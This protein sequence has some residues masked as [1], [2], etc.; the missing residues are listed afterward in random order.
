MSKILHALGCTARA[1][2]R[3]IAACWR[4]LWQTLRKPKWRHG[5]YGFALLAAAVAVGILLNIAVDSLEDTYGWRKDFSFNGYATTGA[6]TQK[7]LDT[8][9]QDVNL[10]LLYQSGEMDSQLYEV[11]E[12]YARLSDRVHVQP[13]D[14]AQDPG[15]LTRFQGN[16]KTTLQADSVVVSCDATG[17]YKVLSYDDFV[18]QGYNVEKGTFEIAGLAYEKRLTEALVYVTQTDVPV[19]GVLQGHGELTADTLQNMT[20][21]LTSNNYETRALSLRDG[22]TLADVD[23]LLIA[24][25]QLD[26]TENE[27]AQIKAFAEA[28]GSLFVLRDYTD[29]LDLPNYR[30]LLT[31][32]GVTPIQGVVVAGEQDQGSYYG[33]RIYL[34]PYFNQ[35]ELTQ[36]LIS[37]KMDVLLLAGA[38]AFETPTQTDSALSAATV[39][40]S[41]P[42][43]YVR[44]PGASDGTLDYQPG[45]R[46]GELTLAIL[47]GRMHPNGNVSRMFAIGNST[48]FTDEYLYQR[49]FN[50][51]FL[52]QVM[53]ELLPQK[54]VSL[55]IIAKAAFHPGLVAGSQ[56]MGIALLTALPLL[57]LLAAVLVLGPRR[58]R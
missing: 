53:G 19:V 11:L 31:N 3:W 58:N 20:D 50:Q 38:C 34:L 4:G 40:K 8:L 33:E 51:E 47:A 36:P 10:Y 32:Y 41:G 45:D 21:F 9:T 57:V 30:S 17:R 27:L 37:G 23:L 29:P 43:A 2:G 22:D 5:G 26:L 46:K 24:D 12:R 7:A 35:M 16:L 18:T 28:G 15:F 44:G 42:N 54:T 55:D 1:G 14:L 25:P 6:E 49:T 48:V 13:T 39:L 56:T 52:L